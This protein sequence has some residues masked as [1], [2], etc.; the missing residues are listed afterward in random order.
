MVMY[1]DPELTSQ[2]HTKS[3]K[4]AQLASTTKIKKAI[5]RWVG[6]AEAWSHQ[7]PH[8]RHGNPQVRETSEKNMEL[9]PEE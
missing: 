9:C 7:I 6:E 8:P 4:L 3:T 2:G 1:K 5:L